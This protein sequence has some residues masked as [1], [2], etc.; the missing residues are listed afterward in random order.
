MRN[1]GTRARADGVAVPMPRWNLEDA[2]ARLSEVVREAK[3]HGPQVVTQRGHDA[4]VI[5]AAD[6]FKALTGSTPSFVAFMASLDLD[7]LNL[8]RD[9]DP[10]RELDL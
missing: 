7:G 8:E 9:A 10:G 6:E 4:V 1:P 3:A 2:K 5:M